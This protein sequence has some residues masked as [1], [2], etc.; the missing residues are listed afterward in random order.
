MT[1][2][3]KMNSF[4]LKCAYITHEYIQNDE[5][6]KKSKRE[7]KQ[8]VQIEEKKRICQRIFQYCALDNI[9]HKLWFS[10]KELV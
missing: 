7:K 10:V 2:T 3:P 1:M 6:Q 9:N 5:L 8:H 4:G